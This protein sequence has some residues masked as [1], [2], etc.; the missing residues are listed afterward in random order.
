MSLIGLSLSLCIRD[1]IAGKVREEDVKQITTGTC[2]RTPC[3]WDALLAR[4]AIHY[5]RKDPKRGIEIANRFLHKDKIYQPRA[6]GQ[7]APDILNG[8]WVES[9]PFLDGIMNRV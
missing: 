1:I 7:D 6:D 2:A 8:I 5:W 4:Y 9:D 3:E